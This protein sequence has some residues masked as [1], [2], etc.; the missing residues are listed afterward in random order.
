MDGLLVIDKP[1]ELTSHDVVA[2]VRRIL[3]ERSAGHLGTLDP[4]ATGVLPIVVGSMT[5]LAQFY[6]SA[7]KSYEGEIRFGFAT[8]TYDAAGDTVGARNPVA[9]TLEQVRHAAAAYV[10]VIKQVPPPFS[11]K[12]IAGVPAYKLARRKERVD[13]EPVTVEVK[14]LEISSLEGDRAWF[15]ARVASGTY[16]RSIAHELGKSLGVGAH[17]G[18]LR[19]TRVGEFGLADAVTLEGLEA[20][21]GHATDVALHNIRYRTLAPGQNSREDEAFFIHPRRLLP[22]FPSVTAPPEGLTKV[23]HG[24]AVNLPDVSR[25]KYVKVFRGQTELVAIAMR[26]AGTLFHPKVVL[27]T[28]P[29]HTP[30]QAG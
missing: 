17:L 14:Q 26:I 22:D 13:L 12:K 2:R 3:K 18:A 29:A 21:I 7:E 30:I 20:A 28:A 15:Q 11:A 25:S 5:R 16:L 4:L 1:S 19:R 8:D 27:A 23:V 9:L 10:G 6:T 24:N